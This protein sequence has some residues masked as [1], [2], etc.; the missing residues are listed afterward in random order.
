MD[1]EQCLNLIK[2]LSAIESWGFANKQPLP[3]YLQDTL[4]AAVKLLSNEVLKNEPT[5]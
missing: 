3:D 1:K 4:A 5:T 2:L